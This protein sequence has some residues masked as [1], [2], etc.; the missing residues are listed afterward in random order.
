M[1]WADKL[2]VVDIVVRRAGKAGSLVGQA[3]QTMKGHAL[4]EGGFGFDVV[5]SRDLE[6]F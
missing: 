2:R 5:A 6:G 3:R 1:F 4:Q